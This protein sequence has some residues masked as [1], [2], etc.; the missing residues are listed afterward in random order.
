MGK[1]EGASGEAQAQNV[2]GRPS[3]DR[4]GAAGKVGEGEG[5]E[6]EIEPVEPAAM[7]LE[8]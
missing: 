2:G 8:R 3:K 6:E 4:G 5:G 7:I 1:G